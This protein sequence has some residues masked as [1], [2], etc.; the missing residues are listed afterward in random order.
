[1]ADIAGVLSDI[2]G[3]VNV[4]TGSA[5]HDDH[6]H[7]EALTAE[8]VR[9]E[10]VVFPSTAA[11]V[12]AIVR[13]AIEHG[14]ALTARGSGTGLSGASIP[15]PGGVIVAF[16]RMAN[17]IE[18]D[19]ENHVAVVQPGVTLQQL[20]EATA[21]QGLVYPVFPG[22]SSASLGG[23]VATNAGGMRAVKYGVTRHQVLGLEAVL[24]TGEVV[25]TGGRFVK[26]TTGYD[27]TQL[28]IG[29]EGTLALVTEATL[30]LYPRPRHAATVLAPFATLE[31]IT[32]AVPSIVASGIGPLLVEYI[33]LVSMGGITAAAGLDLGVAAHVKEQALAYLVVVL[34]HRR[35][36]RLDEDVEELATLIAELGAL[37][38]YVLPSQAGAQ[39]IEARER[40]FWAAKAAGADD[41]VDMVV[42]RASIAT[43]MANVSELA[44]A[45]QSLV[46]GCGH[47]GDGN[48]HLSVF[49]GDA[50]VRRELIHDIFAAGMALGGAISGEHGIG[51]EKKSYLAALEDP[52]KLALMRRIKA[53]FDPAGILNPGT[54]FDPQQE[55]TR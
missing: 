37:D 23:N 39:L 47:A 53:A 6:C 49:Q 35:D 38:V 34:E 9:P 1:M 25:R 18:I 40:A 54:I 12:A 55:H 2:V 52:A 30:K 45:S 31:A 51:T 26:A 33:D 15:V 4:L 42:P 5:I 8:A 3:A 28:V 43:Y 27:L 46:V 10:A 20:D 36:D 32:A 11:E 48:V 24:G 13:A 7:D 41:I 16:D 21:A 22:E 44:D 50:E 29:S 17:I 14:I 19:L